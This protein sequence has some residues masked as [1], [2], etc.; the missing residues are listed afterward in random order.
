MAK[1]S[2]SKIGKMARRKGATGERQL[3]I[4][5]NK[6]LLPDGTPVKAERNARNGIS[7]TDLAHNI[8]D[9][10]IECK[11]VQGMR[12]GTKLLRDAMEQAEEE[13][14]YN[15]GKADWCV[16]FRENRRSWLVATFNTRLGSGMG[17]FV[18]PYASLDP[19]VMTL[20]TFMLWIGCGKK[21]VE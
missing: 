10:H 12:L 6:W 4:E 18:R 5:L 7:T 9:W 14:V 15:L 8:P 1:K 13:A 20:E 11:R 16:M 2:R 21:E 3:A 19:I 17:R